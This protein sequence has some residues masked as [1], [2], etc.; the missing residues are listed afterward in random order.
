MLDD[1]GFG[2]G[3]PEDSGEIME[4]D[5]SGDGLMINSSRNPSKKGKKVGFDKEVT[6]K[7]HSK[8]RA[9]KAARRAAGIAAKAAQT[10]KGETPVYISRRKKDFEDS[11]SDEETLDW[12][13]F[14]YE[15][16]KVE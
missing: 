6:D 8:E 1:D 13:I 2:G 15:N 4:E 9:K 16:D 14:Y 11:A 5:V 7:E 10:K 12:I 3:T